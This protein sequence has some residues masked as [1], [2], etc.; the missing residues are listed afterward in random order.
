MIGASGESS[1]GTLSATGAGSSRTT[2]LSSR[3]H[4]KTR[5]VFETLQLALLPGIGPRTMTLLID[6]FGTAGAVLRAGSGELAEVSG[7]GKK[8]I[9]VIQTAHHFVDPLQVMKWCHEHE[10]YVLL[11]SLDAYPPLLREIA[12]PP[13]L[14]FMQGDLRLADQLA[15]AIGGTRH[16]TV[17]GLK[18]AEHFG[19]MLAKSGVT[20]V[21]GLARGIDAA[22][23]RGALHGGGRT[24]G[25]LGG[26]LGQIYPREHR[27]LAR[28]VARR[29]AVISEYAPE[30]KPR[31]GMFPQRNRLISGLSL[32]VLVVEA[33]ER[34]GAL[35]TARLATE[36]NREVLAIPGPINSRVSRGCNLLIRD[37]AKLVQSIDDVLEELGPLHQPVFTTDGR[38]IHSGEDLTSNA[39]LTRD[40]ELTLNAVE[41]SVFAA[42]E[43]TPVPVDRI[44]AAVDLAAPR[45]LAALTVLEVRRLIRRQGGRVQRI[46]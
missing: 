41:R 29:G 44:I 34:S 9:H 45:I 15:V 43:S 6:R 21:S 2:R 12:D 32:A 36:Q 38:A 31:G 11:Q 40:D 26:G 10:A 7:V 46:V 23:H 16:A 3:A 17:Y 22:A 39:E 33:P 35:I 28:Q 27:G 42:I 13:P 8:L 5:E 1:T 18:Q 4:A 37:G 30:A 24:I 25:V 14:M 20:V 19:F